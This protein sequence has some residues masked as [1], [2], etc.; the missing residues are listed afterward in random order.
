MI[1]M[2]SHFETMNQPEEKVT[3]N[4]YGASAIHLG[5]AEALRKTIESRGISMREAARELLPVT[6]WNVSS[7]RMMLHHWIANRK[8]PNPA[9]QRSILEALETPTPPES[10]ID[11]MRMHNLTWDASKRRWVLRLTIDVGKKVV[12][13]RI[14]VRL[15]T[16]D[17]QTAIAKREAVVDVLK[18]LGLTVRP[19]LQKRKQNNNPLPSDQVEECSQ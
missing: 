8:V 5:F 17:A 11:E 1:K 9:K 10:V 16:C 2:I 14:C 12:G 7:G 18:A 13:K 15:K 6:R 4:T 3:G 19:R